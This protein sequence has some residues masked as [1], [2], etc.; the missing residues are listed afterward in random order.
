MRH[1]HRYVLEYVLLRVLVEHGM[2]EDERG[3]ERK[4][5]GHVVV[6]LQVVGPIAQHDYLLL[7][8]AL[9]QTVDE[10]EAP[11]HQLHLVLQHVRQ[12]VEHARQHVPVGLLLQARLDQAEHAAQVELAL[13]GPSLT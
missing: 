7:V 10:V 5:L 11:T 13:A 6:D 9:E 4:E 2:V 12:I 1:A 3:D 8:Q